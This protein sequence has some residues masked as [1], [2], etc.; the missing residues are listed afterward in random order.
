M[1]IGSVEFIRRLTWVVVARSLRVHRADLQR[2][3]HRS[4]RGGDLNEKG[5]DM[6]GQRDLEDMGALVTGATSGIGKAAASTTSRD[7]R[8]VGC[9]LVVPCVHDGTPGAGGQWGET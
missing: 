4:G 2:P 6:N 7:G 9:L 8:A 1:L 5:C 3:C